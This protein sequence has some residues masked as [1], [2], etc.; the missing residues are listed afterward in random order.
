VSELLKHLFRSCLVSTDIV[1]D[2]FMRRRVSLCCVCLCSQKYRQ[3]S[4]LAAL[5]VGSS[6]QY[7]LDSFKVNVLV[8]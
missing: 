6:I 5:L 7:F 4:L 2:K 3:G 8:I 1:Y